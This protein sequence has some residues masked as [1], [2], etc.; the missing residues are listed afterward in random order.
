M[1][2]FD[3]NPNHVL[4]GLGGTG[5]KVLKAFK[6]RLYIEYPDDKKRNALKFPAVEFIYVDSTHEMMKPNDPTFRVFGKDFSFKP[7]EFVDIKS[8]DLGTI[9]D[10]I[11]S[12]PGLKH[13]VKSAEAMRTTLGEVGAA[14]GQK[15]RAGR[16]LFASNCNKYLA[17]LSAKYSDLKERTRV[18]DSLHVHIFTGLAG[19]TGSG[20]I[21][22][23]IT[24]TRLKYPYATIDVYAMVPELDIPKGCQ[25]GRYHQNG[26][27][28]LKELSALNVCKFLPSN[29]INGE[30]HVLFNQ[31]PNKQFGLMLYSNVNENGIVVNSFTELPELLAD[32][33]YFRLFLKP[34]SGVND[35]F[36]RAWS[37]ENYSDYLVEYN[38]K[39]KSGDLE[40]ARTK[41][42]SSFGIKRV[43]YP[44]TRI[45]EHISYSISEHLVRQMQYNNFSENKGYLDEPV[46]K[47]YEEITQNDGIMRDWKLD[48]SHLTLNE[49][50]LDSEK[51]VKSIE[52]FWEDTAFFNT[53]EDSKRGDS[54]NPCAFNYNFCNDSFEH[55]FRLKMGV[56]SYYQEKSDD[57]ILSNYAQ[58]II[59]NIESHLFT[60]WYEGQYSMYDLSGICDAILKN[61]RKRLEKLSIEVTKYSE[62]ADEL[63]ADHND[64]INEYS[65]LPLHQ[66]VFGKKGELYTEDQSVLAK[67]FI[68]KTMKCA[69]SFQE[70]LMSRLKVKF[71]E[72]YDEISLFITK[73]ARSQELLLAAI[74]NRTNESSALNLHQN[75]IEVEE[76]DKMTSFEHKLTCK[77]NEMETFAAFMRKE[78]VKIAPSTHFIDIASKI[79]DY[80]FMEIATKREID[81]KEKDKKESTLYDLICAYHVKEFSKDKV[82]GL[83][84]LE[85]LM[86][87]LKTDED[88]NEFARTIINESGVFL[89]L[90]DGE[91][92]KAF[93]NNP[94]PVVAPYSVNRESIIICMPKCEGSDAL[95]EFS[96]KLTEAMRTEFQP[97]EGRKI[98]FDVSDDRMN[99]ITIVS[100]KCCFP[101]RA[102]EWLPQYAKEY[103]E[104]INSQSEGNQ[105]HARTLLHI[106]G[107]GMQLPLLEGEGEG[108]KGNDVIPYLFIAASP[109]LQ[110]LKY[111][112]DDCENEGWCTITEGD[113]GIQ[114]VKLISENFTSILES[115]EFTSDLQDKI[116]ESV[117]EF[118]NNSEIKKSDRDAVV[119]RINELM[120]NVV[121]KECSSTTSPKFKLY[122]DSANKAL[123]M[124]QKK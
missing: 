43:M 40:R 89:K 10:N 111:D 32:A 66:K 54:R 46:L 86:K 92:K 84:V 8:V 94:N 112:K 106:E 20:S 78:I 23:V 25:A 1:A 79:D 120:R 14:A 87:I 13:V 50:I 102:L 38:F 85:L 81:E 77:K 100:I 24:Q 97:N 53:Y 109:A 121:Y 31:I 63:L 9:L 15:R 17:A 33:V 105:K 93:N 122:G 91:V 39:S 114:S 123:S 83:N 110:I 67:L 4:V 88:I 62:Q 49:K 108:P 45:I 72:Y 80:T 22:D 107:D 58:E 2:F 69:L 74:S 65:T 115:E 82:L 6:K 12:F 98:A 34:K 52:A 61:I 27:A 116:V 70:R 73:L 37:A 26:Y 68:A 16:I 59:N 5:G 60:K 7:H 117:E 48:D 101:M 18:G 90:N 113:W 21:I 119:T 75:I 19:G 64:I 29:V 76:N 118:I 42:L 103:N 55:K 124:I 36:L 44:E 35:D 51:S 56:E 28:A 99:E 30:E 47:H 41:A 3:S 96:K 11:N 71:E 57:E 104:L 95:K